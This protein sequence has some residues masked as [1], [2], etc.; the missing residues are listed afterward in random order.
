M[1]QI[2]ATLSL[3]YDVD[4]FYQV[5]AVKELHFSGHLERYKEIRNILDAITEATG[6]KFSIKERTIIVSQ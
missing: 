4:V 1:E 2:M 3:W 5:E 6:V